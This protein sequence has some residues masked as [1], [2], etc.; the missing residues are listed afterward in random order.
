V[1][2]L[3]LYTSLKADLLTVTGVKHV[4]L[5]NNQLERE[6]VEN[7]F[8][9]PAVFIEFG[10]QEYKD[11]GKGASVQQYSLPVILHICFENYKDTDEDVLTLVDAVWQKVHKNQYGE[12]G[13]LLRRSEKMDSDHPNVQDYIQEYTTLGRDVLTNTLVPVTATLDLTTDF[14]SANQI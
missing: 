14:K 10:Q 13:E 3:A 1:G 9:Y 7:P 2:K 6:N 5:W 11:L 8:Q 12:F 4:A